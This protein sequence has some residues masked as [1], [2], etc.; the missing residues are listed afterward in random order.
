MTPKRIKFILFFDNIF[1]FNSKGSD[2][3]ASIFDMSIIIKE[4]VDG[5]QAGPSLIIEAPPPL[6]NSQRC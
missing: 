6:P 3:I 5:N 4:R 2:Q 1:Y